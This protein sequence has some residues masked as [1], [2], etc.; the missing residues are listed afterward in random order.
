MLFLACQEDIALT[1]EFSQS[2]QGTA[3]LAKP[4]PTLEV[5][6]RTPF[7]T[8]DPPYFWRGEIDF[9]DYGVY[10]LV[11]ISHG[12]P[13]VRGQSSHFSEEYIVYELGKDYKNPDN[14]LLYGHN[15]GIVVNANRVP[16]P[17]KFLSN[18]KVEVAREPFTEWLGRSVH[19]RGLVYWTFDAQGLPMPEEAVGTFRLN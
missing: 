13:T 17:V 14:Y 12:A 9:G 5:E 2:D 10:G 6:V 1:P 7:W 15:A 8:D 11:F 16:D 18:G 19:I 3:S 4:A